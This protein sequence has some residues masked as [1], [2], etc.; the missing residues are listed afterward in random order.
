MGLLLVAPAFAGIPDATN[1]KVTMF[2]GDALGSTTVLEPAHIVTVPANGPAPQ[3]RAEIIVEVRDA[4]NLVVANSRVF[5]IFSKAAT[6]TICFCTTPAQPNPG[7]TVLADGRREWHA[8]TD[9]NGIARIWVSAGACVE[10]TGVVQIKANAPA[11]PDPANSFPLRLYNVLA[12]FDNGGAGGTIC[13]ANVNAIDFAKY[14]A[15][16]KGI[17]PYSTCMDYNGDAAVNAIDFSRYAQQHTR[18]APL[19]VCTGY[20]GPKW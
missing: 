7:S 16:H 4:G 3:R 14:A 6:D 11:D 2:L 19:P 18:T 1:S 15:V 10:E 9:V 13:D 17:Q 5:V 20:T 12:S 8:D